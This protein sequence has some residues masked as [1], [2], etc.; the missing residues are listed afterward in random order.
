VGALDRVR[1]L[2]HEIYPSLLPA[3]GL[4]DALRAAE[5]DAGPVARYPLELE[6][7]VYFACRALRA[8]A[9]RLHVWDDSGTVHLEAVGAFD[10]AAI[11]RARARIVSVGG[12]LTASVGGVS[13]TV[14]ASSSAR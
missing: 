9:T 7:A 4:A 14:P 10:D 8:G 1:G 5:I 6:E 11:A 2:A 12:Q 13:A 3:R